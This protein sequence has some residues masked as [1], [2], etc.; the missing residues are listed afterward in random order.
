[1]ARKPD[2]TSNDNNSSDANSESEQADH[3][4][5]LRNKLLRARETI[6][7]LRAELD[8]NALRMERQADIARR[9][10]NLFNPPTLPRLEGATFSVKY[11]PCAR[12]GGDIYDV[13]DMGNGCVGIFVADIAGF[14]MAAVLVT[15]LT[16]MS[17]DAFRQNEYS[18]KRILE[19]VNEH[20]VNHTLSNQFLTAFLGVV[21]LETLRMKYV[22][23]AH[24][25]P[26]VY[27]ED[28]FDLLDTDGLCCGMFDEPRFEEKEVQLS[29]GDR[30]FLFTRGLVDMASPSGKRY[31]SARLHELL[32]GNREK[33]VGDVMRVL[34]DDFNTHLADAE[35]VEDLTLLAMEL[36][37]LEL[38][39]NRVVIPSEPQQIH[40]I[41]E[42]ILGELETLNY[43]ERVLFGVRLAIEE[44]VINAIKHGNKMD[45]AKDVT[46]V[47]SADEKECV[48]TVED[49]GEGF[50]PNNVPDPTIDE[51]IE[52]SHGR[53]LVL[54]KAYMDEVAYNDRG[55]CV[56]MK[57]KA[58]WAD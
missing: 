25:C 22:N 39:V 51:N 56:T 50:D 36:T 28:S 54:M 48:I 57:K 32:K 58:P 14:G 47:W 46:V 49:E 37:S 4:A 11:Q 3:M 52:L 45:K 34:I 38:K 33:P 6:L 7:T 41:E 16:K 5:G 21:D 15:A 1:M 17:F 23:A 40:R 2:T 12:V 9:F 13:F 29:A 44:A 53:G 20:L 35:Q 31:K 19:K 42:R 18:P 24:P 26:V 27:S 43:G 55:T 30:L 8:Q 10:Q